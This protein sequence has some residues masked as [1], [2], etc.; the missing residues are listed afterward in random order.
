M[1]NHAPRSLAATAMFAIALTLAACTTITGPRGWSQT[2]EFVGGGTHTIDVRD[3]SGRIDDVE[4]DPANVTAAPDAVANPAGQPNVLLVRWTGGACDERTDIAIAPA[5]QGLAITIR[6]TVR[7]G[8]CNAIG[9]GHVLRLTAG[10]PLPA[11]VVS[12]TT[13]P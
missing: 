7:P 5:G 4:I 13:T 8:A 6:T 3:T 1:L 9:I 10:D 11:N 12:V 2:V